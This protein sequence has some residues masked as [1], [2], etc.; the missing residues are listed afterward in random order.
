MPSHHVNST[1]LEC[2]AQQKK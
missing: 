1:A 2:V